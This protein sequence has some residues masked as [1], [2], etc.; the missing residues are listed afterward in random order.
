[1]LKSC[2]DRILELA[3]TIKKQQAKLGTKK[4]FNEIRDDLRNFG[5]GFGRDKFFDLLRRHNMLIKRRKKYAVT[6]NSNHPFYK[7]KDEIKGKPVVRPNQVWVSDITYLRTRKG[8]I[9]LSLITDV[10]SRKIVGWH[11]DI[12]LGVEGTLKAL[13]RALGQCKSTEG[14]IHHSDRGIQYCCYPYTDLLKKHGVIISMGEAGNCY[15][16]AIAERVN[17]I[18]KGEYMLDSTFRD[19]SQAEKSVKQAIYLYNYKR[20]HWSLK[21]KKPADVYEQENKAA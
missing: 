17:G 2:E 18:L 12:S 21:L 6:T 1:M 15:D 19:H 14:L 8:F 7:Y 4:V 13:K 5:R 20:P 3:K 10:Y 9:Y 16:N 11:V